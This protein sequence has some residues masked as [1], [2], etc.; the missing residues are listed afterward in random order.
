MGGAK[1]GPS[2]NYNLRL[3]FD[4]QKNSC[5]CGL[6]RQWSRTLVELLNLQP[7]PGLPGF[8]LSLPGLSVF[9]LFCTEASLPSLCFAWL[10]CL[11][12][13]L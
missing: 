12:N 13:Y 10:V 9:F 8:S 5:S 7:L 1:S 6:A 4:T 3:Q 11:L 2:I